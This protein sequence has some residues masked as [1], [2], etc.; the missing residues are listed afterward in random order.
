MELILELSLGDGTSNLPFLLL[1]CFLSF[2]IL[3]TG[4]SIFCVSVLGHASSLGT[5][6]MR[7]VVGL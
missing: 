7:G 4:G 1:V 2:S 3:N 6:K 5:G